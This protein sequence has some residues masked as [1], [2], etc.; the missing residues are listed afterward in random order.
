MSNKQTKPSPNV[1]IA[2]NFHY[3]KTGEKRDWWGN[4][5]V[6]SRNKLMFGKSLT[7][8]DDGSSFR[9]NLNFLEMNAKKTFQKVLEDSRRVCLI[10]GKN[11]RQSF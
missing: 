6:Q 3:Q 7:A 11:V 5:N 8:V 4:M 10:R 2:I 9:F 1:R